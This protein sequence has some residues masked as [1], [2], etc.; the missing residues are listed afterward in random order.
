VPPTA[1][2]LA[3]RFAACSIDHPHALLQLAFMTNSQNVARC[4][5]ADG[6]VTMHLESMRVTIPSNFLNQSKVLMDALSSA[7]DPSAI[8]DFT[9]AA[10]A[11]WLEVWVYCF[12]SQ[13]EGLGN[14]DSTRLVNCLMVSMFS[15]PDARLLGCTSSILN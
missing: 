8:K 13:E 15:N 12:V 1:V 10:P 9:L 6:T 14:I 7:C 2:L 4:I 3:H 11:E 5:I